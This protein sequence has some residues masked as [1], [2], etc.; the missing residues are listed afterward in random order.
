MGEWFNNPENGK[1]K[2]FEHRASKGWADKPLLGYLKGK[3]A[4][5]IDDE[6]N[7]V[8]IVPYFHATNK[9]LAKMWIEDLYTQEGRLYDVHDIPQWVDHVSGHQK[10]VGQFVKPSIENGRLYY[11]ETMGEDPIKVMDPLS[12]EARKVDQAPIKDKIETIRGVSDLR[13]KD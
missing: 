12:G 6:D 8:T 4:Y 1:S 13:E 3:T 11:L 9:S 2:S 7:L 10:M 5:E